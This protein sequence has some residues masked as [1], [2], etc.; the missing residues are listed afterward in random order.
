MKKKPYMPRP[1]AQRLV[2]QQNFVR[3]LNDYATALGIDA[4]TL[5]MLANDLL[6]TTWIVQVIDLF[7]H[8]V[9]ERVKFKDVFFDGHEG[10]P[11][12]GFPVMPTMPAN[13]ATLNA[14]G[15]FKRIEKIVQQVKSNKNYTELIGKD[16]G[17]IGA[18]QDINWDTEKPVL[19][20]TLQSNKVSIKFKKGSSVGIKIYSRRTTETAWSFLSIATESPYYDTRT[21]IVSGQGETREYKAVYLL[22]D[23]EVGQES[24]I[25]SISVRL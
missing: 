8:T 22:H 24:E 25:Y 15:A 5:L 20:L 7:K 18:E 23:E 14:S 12:G 21:N 6:V 19:T 10:V 17:I 9:N 1:Y 13:P 11:M 4:A 3:K 2:W 16:L